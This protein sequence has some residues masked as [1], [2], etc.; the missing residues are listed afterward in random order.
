MS[1]TFI[2]LALSSMLFALCVPVEA[3]QPGKVARIGCL[4]P[5]VSSD[6]TA[7]SRVEG[8]RKGLRNLGYVEG[9]NIV[10]EY[11]FADGKLD[12][13]PHLAAEL[14]R[15]K[16]DVIVTGGNEA[17]RASKSATSTIPIVMAFSGDPVGTGF[18]ASLARPGG[19]ITG[20]TSVSQELVGKQLEILKEVAPHVS[21]LGMLW[22]PENPLPGS[23]LKEMEDATKMLGVTFQILEVRDPNDIESAFSTVRKDRSSALVILPGG[24]MTTHRKRIVELAAKRR[25]PAVYGNSRFVEAG[26]LMSYGAVRTEDFPRAAYYVDKILKGAKPAELP[27]EQ[28]TKFEFIINLKAAKQIGLTIP[29]SVLYRA[30]R[31]IK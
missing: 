8:F 9:K 5:N 26:G 3:Q 15:L 2:N 20:L 4:L 7:Q 29:Q 27:V 16:V 25:I 13:L 11:R 21:H 22:N 14:V 30:D 28:P 19:N 12:R 1:R 31:V 10:I 6:P 18:V 24:F 23:R 17:I